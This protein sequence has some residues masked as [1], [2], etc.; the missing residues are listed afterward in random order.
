MTL[1]YVVSCLC[2]HYW[3]EDSYVNLQDQNVYF[4]YNYVTTQVEQLDS[5]CCKTI[6]RILHRGDVKQRPVFCL[7]SKE[8][9][10][11]AD[12]TSVII[13]WSSLYI[14]SQ[15]ITQPNKQLSIVS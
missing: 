8:D 6:R 14:P 13:N 12:Q 7:G 2:F 11:Y 15:T 5:K 1:S 10:A 4:T 3:K 9:S